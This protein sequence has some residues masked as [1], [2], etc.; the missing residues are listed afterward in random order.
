MPLLDLNK[1]NPE[2]NIQKKVSEQKDAA[3]QDLRLRQEQEKKSLLNAQ[4]NERKS[5]ERRHADQKERLKNE[6]N[7]QPNLKS[8]CVGCR[9]S[10]RQST[11][12]RW[13]GVNLDVY[14]LHPRLKSRLSVSGVSACNGFSEGQMF[15]G[16]EIKRGGEDPKKGENTEKNKESSNKKPD[17]SESK[18]DDES[19]QNTK[20]NKKGSET[21]P[22][23][24]D[25]PKKEESKKDE[26]KD[27]SDNKEGKEDESSKEEKKPSDD[28]ESKGSKTQ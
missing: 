27:D 14:C 4:D 28:A 15:E 13:G 2:G 3:S 23:G 11:E 6:K 24:D 18:K 25:K 20:D 5:Q 7:I 16:Q 26:G 22:K 10:F 19:G 21:K 1:V 9:H 17:D 12:S 8:L